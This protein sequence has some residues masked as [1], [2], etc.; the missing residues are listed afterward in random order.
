MIVESKVNKN[1]LYICIINILK[2]VFLNIII[3]K[4][5]IKIVEQHCFK[6][7]INALCYENIKFKYF[8][9]ENKRKL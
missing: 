9:Q 8:F 3:I 6:N 2:Y 1:Q 7:N 5:E 4:T